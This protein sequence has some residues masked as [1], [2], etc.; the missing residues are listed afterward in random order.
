MGRIIS[1]F[2][3]IVPADSDFPDGRSKDNLGNNTGTPMNEFTMGDT[4]QFFAKLF[5][6]AAIVPNG[7]PDGPY[8]EW[9]YFDAFTHVANRYRKL[10]ILSASTTLTADYINSLIVFTG[11]SSGQTLTISSPTSS[12]G[13]FIEILNTSSHAVTISVPGPHQEIAL[14]GNA[15]IIKPGTSFKIVRYFNISITDLIWY[16]VG[17]W[18]MSDNLV[19][20]GNWAATGATPTAKFTSNNTVQLLGLP[21]NA[22]GTWNS[23]TIELPD[24]TMFPTSTKLIGVTIN[25]SGTY[26]IGIIQI[27]TGGIITITTG[28]STGTNVRFYLDGI[29]YSVD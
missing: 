24:S 17:Q 20:N 1:N 6:E 11:S 12:D 29:S 9:Q 22:S 7:L 19:L 23:D 25:D 13:D 16:P 28:V 10:I 26:R 14:I 5:R 15:Y 3:N 27:T 18:E 8:E 4:Q 2:P 21:T